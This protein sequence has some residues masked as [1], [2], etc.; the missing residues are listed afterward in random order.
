MYVLIAKVVGVG[1]PNVHKLNIKERGDRK[2]IFVRDIE[3][4][5]TGVVEVAVVAGNEGEV[6]REYARVAYRSDGQVV[7][8][9]KVLAAKSGDIGKEPAFVVVRKPQGE[10]EVFYT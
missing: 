1:K 8:G 10:A 6:L 7:A 5:F 3:I 9:L 2:R 4:G